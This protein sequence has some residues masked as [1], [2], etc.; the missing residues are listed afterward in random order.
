MF[1]IV[2]LSQTQRRNYLQQKFP[3]FHILQNFALDMRLIFSR[4]WIHML[5]ING[6]EL[7][8]SIP[9]Y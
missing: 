7:L 3:E 8:K 9:S 1:D 4:I 2:A 6:I 5:L